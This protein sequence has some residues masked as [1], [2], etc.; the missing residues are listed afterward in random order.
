MWRLGDG[1]EVEYVS[2]KDEFCIQNEEFCINNE[3]LC[4]QNEE[5]CIQNDEFC[6][7]RKQE[8]WR[9]YFKLQYICHFVLEEFRSKMQR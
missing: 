6:R 4:I 8:G 1:L 9:T 5:L 3:E 7:R 2:N